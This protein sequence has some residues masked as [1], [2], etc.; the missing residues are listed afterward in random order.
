MKT[1][2]L[3]RVQER[4]AEHGAVG[5]DQGQVDTEHPVQE[6]ARLAHYHFRELHDHGNDQD[7][8]DR[9]QVS[10]PQGL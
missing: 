4:H 1:V 7:E 10:E 9:A 8:G 3:V 6:R 2:A 5:G